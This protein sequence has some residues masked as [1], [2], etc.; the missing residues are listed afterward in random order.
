VGKKDKKTKS[1]K[2]EDA[3]SRGD[4]ANKSSS[5]SFKS[6]S[7]KLK[8]FHTSTRGV[9][10]ASID[11]KLRGGHIARTLGE[12]FVSWSWIWSIFGCGRGGTEETQYSGIRITFYLPSPDCEEWEYNELG[13]G[14]WCEHSRS[15]FW[16]PHCCCCRLLC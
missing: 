14:R 6:K 9:D 4:D 8:E 15:E 3:E 12:F 16:C 7:S 1:K 2:T 11:V 13:V 5:K 10:A